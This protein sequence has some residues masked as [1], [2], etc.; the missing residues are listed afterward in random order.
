MSNFIG[1]SSVCLTSTRL[2]LLQSFMSQLANILKKRLSH[3]SVSFMPLPLLFVISIS[4]RRRVNNELC[5]EKLALSY[6][7]LTDGSRWFLKK[8]HH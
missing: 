3:C 2:N 7:L 1:D 8:I 6:F 5:V 4:T